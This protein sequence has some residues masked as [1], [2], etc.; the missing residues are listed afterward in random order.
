MAGKR[1]SERPAPEG[2]RVLVYRREPEESDLYEVGTW[3]GTP[4]F[5]CRRC[6]FD[7]FDAARMLAHVLAHVD[8]LDA[9]RDAKADLGVTIM[10]GGELA[11][12]TMEV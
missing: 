4:H 12:E 3:R 8:G 2:S 9:A 10:A 7:T 11:D 6:A 1:V 5:R